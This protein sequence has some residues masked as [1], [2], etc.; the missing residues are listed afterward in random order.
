MT[1]YFLLTGKLPFEGG[2]LATKL[3]AHQSRM[4]QPIHELVPTIDPKLEQLIVKMIQKEPQDRFQSPQELVRAL[5]PWTVQALPPPLPEWFQPS[6]VL[7][8]QIAAQP[9]QSDK[10]PHA[11]AEGHS[12]DT[13]IDT[14][15]S[16]NGPE[17]STAN[18]VAGGAGATIVAVTNPSQ[19]EEPST[20]KIRPLARTKSLSE[21]PTITSISERLAQVDKRRP[22]RR[23]RQ[24]RHILI[25]VA[26]AIPL[27]GILG[28]VLWY[29]I[30]RPRPQLK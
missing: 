9:P 6:A 4:P 30:T 13:T 20:A 18:L 10:T 24:R 14:T 7:P 1:F 5:A 11:S 3:M 22:A 19:E 26:I 16:R 29:V 12:P 27:L 2:S 23:D 21:L 8:I 28:L 15:P 25:G 17:P